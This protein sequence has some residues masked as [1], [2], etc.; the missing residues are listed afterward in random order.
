MTRNSRMKLKTLGAFFLTGISIFFL[1]WISARAQFT[2]SDNPLEFVV[3]GSPYACNTSA[4][5]DAIDKHA[6]IVRSSRLT[7]DSQALL[8]S[9]KTLISK[10]QSR[11]CSII[12]VDDCPEGY[13]SSSDLGITTGSKVMLKNSG[14]MVLFTGTFSRLRIANPACSSL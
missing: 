5:T 13:V 1:T 11:G 3:L 14:G 6:L 7:G 10:M 12:D 4:I 9:T 2:P 8:E